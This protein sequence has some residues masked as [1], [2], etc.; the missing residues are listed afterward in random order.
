MTP[1]STPI[2]AILLMTTDRRS[3]VREDSH[4]WLRIAIDELG[5]I[6]TD[7]IEPGPSL[8]RATQVTAEENW[9]RSTPWGG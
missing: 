4:L 2:F 6:I 5:T 3:M 8:S 1:S 7:M 9:R